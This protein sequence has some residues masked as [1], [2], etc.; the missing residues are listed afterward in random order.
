VGIHVAE[1]TVALLYAKKGKV[2]ALYGKACS[3]M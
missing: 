2:E 3:V 1:I